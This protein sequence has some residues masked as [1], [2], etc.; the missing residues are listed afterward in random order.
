MKLKAKLII[1]GA[2]A[3]ASSG[4]ATTTW[5]VYTQKS[6]SVHLNSLLTN[7]D[8]GIIDQDELNNKNELTRIIANLNTNS[9]IDFN[10]LDFN[11][12]DNKI[13]VKPN[14]DGQKD[15]KGEVELIFQL[16]KELGS[17]INV[18]NLGRIN[19]SDKTNRNLLLNLIKEKNPSLDT[20]KIQLEIQQNKVIVKPKAGDKT[21]KGEVEITFSLS[22]SLSSV[23]NVRN[24]GIINE[25]DKSDK[26]L[27]LNLIK[28]KNPRLDTDK[29]ELVVQ[30]N[31]IIVKPKA[32][33]NTYEG[34]VEIDFEIFTE[35]DKQNIEKINLVWNKEFKDNF[36]TNDGPV[37]FDLGW[38]A[39]KNQILKLFTERLNDNGLNNV[40]I[41]YLEKPLN[42]FDRPRE[43]EVLKF[44]YKGVTIK[45]NVGKFNAKDVFDDYHEYEKGSQN[46]KVTKI[47]SFIS[48]GGLFHIARFKHSVQEVPDQLPSFIKDLSKAFQGSSNQT[49]KG[50][51]KWDTK[52][53]KRM[54]YTFYDATK[55][56]QNIS[57]WD[58]SNVTDMSGMFRSSGF[59]Q[60]IGNW[61][62]SKVVKM[63]CMFTNNKVF[64]KDISS[65]DTSKVTNMSEMFYGAEKFNQDIT[66][67]NTN[68]LKNTESMFKEAKIF[69]QDINTKEVERKDGSKYTAWDVSNVINM[70][71]MFSRAEAFDKPLNNWNVSNVKNMSKMF[72]VSNFNQDIGNWNTE[73]VTDMQSM[74]AGAEKFNQ[75][76]GNWNT[77]NVKNMHNMFYKA[78]TFNQDINTKEVERKDGSKYTAWD[79]SKVKSMS[80]MFWSAESFNKDISSWDT[81]K[82]TTMNNMFWFAKSF[83]QNISTWDVD[84]VEFYNRFI[85]KESKLKLEFIPEKF[86][87]KIKEELNKK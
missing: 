57:G 69:N 64:N 50:I 59:N 87:A 8:L 47:G 20:D 32:G 2:V 48:N 6:K 24:L 63:N 74:F 30:E 76:I 49:I 38:V 58:T 71:E 53:V 70:S 26:N 19:R 16:S 60:N 42:D 33:D 25:S 13:I 67:W 43:N 86:R 29:V 52:N 75:Y 31:K 62:T 78:K 37:D 36:R 17:V 73:N 81:S 55:F 83:E 51:E 11:I 35:Q 44:V 46:K 28:Q 14:K 80:D 9:K 10:K 1:T 84:N 77:S 15:Y 56:N 54:S 12:Q 22:A 61:N 4:A 39:T 72:N 7:L 3:L 79:V 66:K 85:N 82:V 45:L 40:N 23:I 34:E 65:W 18:T 68:S 5:Y 21:Y 27:L 41:S